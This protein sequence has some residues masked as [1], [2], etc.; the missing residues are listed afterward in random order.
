MHRFNGITYTKDCK[1][2]EEPYMTSA[3]IY[4]DIANRT[5]GD[6]Y[7]GVVGPVRSGKSTCLYGRRKIQNQSRKIQREKTH[8]RLCELF[9]NQDIQKTRFVFSDFCNRI[10]HDERRHC[11]YHDKLFRIG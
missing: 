4:R 8:N 9:Q 2:M 7:I 1:T 6:I 5:N 11:V 10:Y 3:N